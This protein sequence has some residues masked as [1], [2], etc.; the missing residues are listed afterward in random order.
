MPAP[1]S[2]SATLPRIAIVSPPR[3]EK[4]LGP[5]TANN[6]VAFSSKADIVA[7]DPLSQANTWAVN[8]TGTYHRVIVSVEDAAG[9]ILRWVTG[10]AD[11][12]TATFRIWAW[13]RILGKGRTDAVGS[14]PVQ[15]DSVEQ[16]NAFPLAIVDLVACAKVGVA[17]GLVSATDRYI[18]TITI[19]SNRGYTNQVVAIG[20]GSD[21]QS[22]KLKVDTANI[23]LLEIERTAGSGNWSVLAQTF[24]AL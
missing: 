9:V 15:G 17:N 21:D 18:D 2:S 6:A 3:D 19:T 10:Q 11:N 20:P 8:G 23:R 12:A 5:T 13:T 4:I 1:T 24:T 7:A 22:A 14:P 16:W